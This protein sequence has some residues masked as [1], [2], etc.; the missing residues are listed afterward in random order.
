MLVVITN[1]LF[2]VCFPGHYISFPIQTE[3]LCLNGMMA[4]QRKSATADMFWMKRNATGITLSHKILT[5]NQ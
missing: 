5:A 2:H 4:T 1:L 3:Q